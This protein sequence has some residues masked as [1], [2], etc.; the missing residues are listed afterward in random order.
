MIQV[1]ESNTAAYTALR[2][3]PITTDQPLCSDRLY[4]EYTGMP[5]SVV[6]SIASSWR[7]RKRDISVGAT[8]RPTYFSASWVRATSTPLASKM[9]VTRSAGSNCSR[10]TWPRRSGTKATEITYTTL[11]SRTTG[12]WIAASGR[13]RAPA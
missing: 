11:P 5:S 12:A 10:S 2:G 1:I 13:F 9:P 8:C 3:T 7:K 4:I 6:A